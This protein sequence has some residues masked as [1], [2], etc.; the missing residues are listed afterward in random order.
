LL[1]FLEGRDDGG[2]LRR[3]FA[4][5]SGKQFGQSSGV[6][7]CLHQE[8][9]PR[10]LVF[11]GAG[12]LPD[13]TPLARVSVSVSEGRDG[14]LDPPQPADC[15]TPLAVFLMMTPKLTAIAKEKPRAVFDAG[16]AGKLVT[17]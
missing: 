16:Q 8:F 2:K 11:G 1:G 9:H 6:S 4:H 17:P 15:L 3:F 14:W 10:E 5:F 12:H 13:S 7:E